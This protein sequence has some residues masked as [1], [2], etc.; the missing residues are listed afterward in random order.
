MTRTLLFLAVAFF[1]LNSAEGQECMIP[2][3]RTCEELEGPGNPCGDVY[4]IPTLL[5]EGPFFLYICP[6]ETGKEITSA[7]AEFLFP[8]HVTETGYR[9]FVTA[10]QIVCARTFECTCG[11]HLGYL[12]DTYYCDTEGTGTPH[13]RPDYDPAP[14]EP[15]CQGEWEGG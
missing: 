2:V 7:S 12:A 4:C 14:M 15:P 11:M 8:A 10:N 3:P 5:Q 1:G 13:N 6:N 9:A